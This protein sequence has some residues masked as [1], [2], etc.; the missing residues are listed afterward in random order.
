MN[1]PG[2]LT[3]MSPDAPSLTLRDTDGG[4]HMGGGTRDDRF[5]NAQNHSDGTVWTPEASAHAA[6]VERQHQ[7]WLATE[8]GAA[9]FNAQSWNQPLPCVRVRRLGWQEGLNGTGVM[10]YNRLD[11]GSTVTLASLVKQ[12]YRVEVVK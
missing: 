11:D 10:L 9:W 5:E 7:E 6:E 3:P 1:L 12:G 8:E 2:W 4:G